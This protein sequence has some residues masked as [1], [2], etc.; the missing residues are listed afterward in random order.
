MLDRIPELEVVRDLQMTTQLVGEDAHVLLIELAGPM[1]EPPEI[2]E[3]ALVNDREKVRLEPEINEL[4]EEHAR[5]SH[6]RDMVPLPLRG[7]AI[8]V[9]LHDHAQLLKEHP[10]GELNLDLEREGF[11]DVHARISPPKAL[12][13]SPLSTCSVCARISAAF[14]F[15]VS[16]RAV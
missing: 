10:Q 9:V 4:C 3:L 1:D 12:T 7:V 8:D 15:S 5:R 6:V 2:V 16:A 11:E 13:S 14:A